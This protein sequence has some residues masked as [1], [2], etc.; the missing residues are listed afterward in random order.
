M[1]KKT[2]RAKGKTNL[3][4]KDVKLYAF[5]PPQPTEEGF[6]R[7]AECGFNLAIIDPIAPYGSEEYLKL[8]EYCD[9]F[10][11]KAVPMCVDWDE[12]HNG[13]PCE[14]PRTFDKTDYSKFES[15]YGAY[16]ADEPVMNTWDDL[17]KKMQRF[18][19]IYPDKVTIVNHYPGCPGPDKSL[20]EKYPPDSEGYGHACARACV[21][22]YC[23]NVLNK[24]KGEKILSFD[25]YPLK[26][27]DGENVL[28]HDWLWPYDYYSAKARDNGYSAWVFVQTTGIKNEE[29][30]SSR[31]LTS[32]RDYRFQ[33]SVALC[34]GFT[35]I[36]SFCYQS[37]FKPLKALEMDGKPTE[38]Y[39]YVKKVNR[40]INKFS[41]IYSQYTWKNAGLN[42]GKKT[43]V[44]AKTCL[45]RM[46]Y[47]VTEYEGITLESTVCDLLI[48]EFKKTGTERSA[49][50]F[51]NYVEPSHVEKNVITVKFKKEAKSVNIWRRGVKSE[52]K[53]VNGKLTFALSTGD[54]VF[55]EINE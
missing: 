35:G 26:V 27:A 2:I 50:M 42:L 7:Y 28:I 6:K 12:N 52:R 18:E 47:N 15:F 20:W 30:T 8:Y 55:M 17:L 48:G 19:S 32:A 46:L 41:A 11:I 24:L 1:A 36:G 21:D 44:Y 33:S 4:P 5:T 43:N 23:E 49:Y 54:G 31:E 45:K 16:M 34:Y 10:G 37:F 40:E 29:Y 13:G 39:Y 25:Y 9:K 22:I 3:E 38:V 51:V 14:F 53:T